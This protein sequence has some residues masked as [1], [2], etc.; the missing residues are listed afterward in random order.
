M[1]SR[2]LLQSLVGLSLLSARKLLILTTSGVFA[3]G[4]LAF[5][6][7]PWRGNTPS[8]RINVISP[9]C[10]SYKGTRTLLVLTTTVINQSDAAIVVF[11][12]DI[13]IK[14]DASLPPLLTLWDETNYSIWLIVHIHTLV[15]RAALSLLL[16]RSHVP[17]AH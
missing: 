14:N 17:F 13:K 9:L 3:E 6:N 16:P 11:S 12:K 8:T 4:T 5:I 7:L 10:A 15:S 1:I 2:T